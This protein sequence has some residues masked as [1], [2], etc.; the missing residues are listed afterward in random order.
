MASVSLSNA[1]TR[2]SEPVG[3]GETIKVKLG[4]V[5]GAASNSVFKGEVTGVEPI[6][7]SRGPARVDIR[8]FNHLHRLARGKKSVTY[9]QGDRQGHRQQDL[10]SVRL[11]RQVRRHAALDQVRAR[12]PAQPDG[13]RVHRL[14]RGA[15]RLRAFGQR[16]GLFFRKRT[17]ADSGITLDYGVNQEARW[18][19]SARLSTANQVSE[20]RVRGWDPDKKRGDRRLGH[21]RLVEAGDKRAR[22]SPTANTR[23]CWPST[24]KRRSPRK[25][26]RT[27]SPS[28]SCR[29]G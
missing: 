4:F 3:E 7:D 19:I 12:L 1:S 24:S 6:Y 26:R 17:D 25:R 9:T 20:V 23:A 10:P 16:Q 27:T 28:R 2:N 5:E 21:A 15:H 18:R 22:R 11:E 8:A 29:S 13:P 14:A